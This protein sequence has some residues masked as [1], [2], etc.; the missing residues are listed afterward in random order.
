MP[1]PLTCPIADDD[2]VCDLPAAG[3][4]LR[5]LRRLHGRCLRETEVLGEAG[6]LRALPEATADLETN[7]G[8]SLSPRN[9]SYGEGL[10]TLCL[11]LLGA[12]LGLMVLFLA[13]LL[14]TAAYLELERRD[15]FA[16][17]KED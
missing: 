6:P 7:H 8:P 1:P 11:W 17:P 15:R 5:F 14:R 12:L 13:V 16:R 9:P 2:A 4:A 3:G 10:V